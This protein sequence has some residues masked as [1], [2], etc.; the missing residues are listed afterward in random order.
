MGQVKSEGFCFGLIE[1]P[2]K[3]HFIKATIRYFEMYE[4]KDGNV[5]SFK[6]CTKINRI[7]ERILP[8]KPVNFGVLIDNFIR[9]SA[10]L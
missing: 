6:C 8:N 1:S 4:C 10:K 2:K 3:D 7:N 9:Y 5:H